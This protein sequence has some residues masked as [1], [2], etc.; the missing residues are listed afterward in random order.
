MASKKREFLKLVK[1]ELIAQYP[2]EQGWSLTEGKE[3]KG[4]K[5][6][7]VLERKEG[8]K[9]YRRVFKAVPQTAISPNDIKHLNMAAR[10]M[11]GRYVKIEG[12][13]LTLA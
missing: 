11:S 9:R 12:K 3:W 5:I 8:S 4:Y 1:N 2:E 6:D 13:F 10:R 7:F